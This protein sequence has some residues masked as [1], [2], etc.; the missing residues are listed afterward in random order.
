MT[1]QKL[2]SSDPEWWDN[3]Y[4]K[5]GPNQWGQETS[6]TAAKAASQTDKGKKILVVGFGYGRELLYLSK[7]GFKV[8]GIEQSKEGTK[9]AKTQL[10]EKGLSYDTLLSE[11]FEDQ[12][13]FLPES[14]NTVMAHRVLHLVTDPVI[15]KKWVK[16][17]ARVLI[18]GGVVC[19]GNRDERNK[20]IN[21]GD[22]VFE[23]KVRRGH[24]MNLWSKEDFIHYFEPYF[25]DFQ[26]EEIIE[27]E[28]SESEVMCHITIMSA[29]KK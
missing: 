17:A 7:Q 28:S 11:K 26:F 5:E 18:P 15:I 2:D 20:E 29:T 4:A 25:K 1:H 23:S 3:R 6:I 19:I 12:S 8:S 14:F 21:R 24:L 22:Q 9:I 10:R 13:I 27:P 16:M